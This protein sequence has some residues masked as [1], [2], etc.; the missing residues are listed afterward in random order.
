[1]N[2]KEEKWHSVID[3][4]KIRRALDPRVG[5][6]SYTERQSGREGQESALESERPGLGLLPGS[7]SC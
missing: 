1:M 4:E 6:G 5:T 2:Y 7:I 3:T